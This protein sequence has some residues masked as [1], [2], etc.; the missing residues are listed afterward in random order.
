MSAQVITPESEEVRL[1][2]FTSWL[3]EFGGSG[4]CRNL[5]SGLDSQCITFKRSCCFFKS[6]QCFLSLELMIS[7]T[8]VERENCNFSRP[9]NCQLHL[10]LGSLDYCFS[11]VR[12]LF[13]VLLQEWTLI[14]VTYSCTLLVI[15][16]SSLSISVHRYQI[17]TILINQAQ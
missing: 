8:P 14:V 10:Y 15:W 9:C 13:D 16:T 2:Y 7:S 6:C 12:V 5:I 11:T 1:C 4:S 17:Q 3:N